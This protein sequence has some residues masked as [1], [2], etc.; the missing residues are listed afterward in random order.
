MEAV[1]YASRPT[2]SGLCA[3]STSKCLRVNDQVLRAVRRTLDD[4][5]ITGADERDEHVCDRGA[6]RERHR[7]ARGVEIVAARDLMDAHG[8][9]R[10]WSVQSNADA[11]FQSNSTSHGGF[12]APMAGNTTMESVAAILK[13]DW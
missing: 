11:R 5:V 2:V 3:C 9:R 4:D 7:H 1:R 10:V 12:A 8:E 6:R 13:Q